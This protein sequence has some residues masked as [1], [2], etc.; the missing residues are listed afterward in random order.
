MVHI[1][2][3]STCF[4]QGYELNALRYKREICF[5]SEQTKKKTRLIIAGG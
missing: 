4:H 1:L 5:E 2:D 3:A